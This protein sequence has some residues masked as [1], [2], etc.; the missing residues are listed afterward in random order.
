MY[1]DGCGCV[2]VLEK[3]FEEGL[4]NPARQESSAAAK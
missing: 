2:G 3:G 4:I 1:T